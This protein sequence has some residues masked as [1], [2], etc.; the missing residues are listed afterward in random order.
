MLYGQYRFH[1]RLDRNA[2]L[3]AY[4]GSTFRGAFG[5][6]LKQVVCALKRQ[7]CDDCL[8]RGQCLYTRVFET[9]LALAPE[10][11]SRMAQV[12]HPFVIQPPLTEQTHFP[13]GADF[14]FELLLFGEF[15][16]HLPYFIY[17]FDRMGHTGLG[18]KLNGRR[19][20]FTLETV[21]LNNAEIYSKTTR[22]IQM[23]EYVPL[24]RLPDPATADPPTTRVRITLETPLRLK[25]RNRFKADLPFHVLVRAML[26]R[27]SSLMA[28]YGNGEPALD[29]TDLVARAENI[30][31][32]DST[33]KW[34][35]LRRYSNRQNS[36]LFI[37]GLAGTITYQGDMTDY[38]PL[39]EF[40]SKTHIGKQTA[41]GLG[42]ISAESVDPETVSTPG[43]IE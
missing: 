36:K 10:K 38:L 27:I 6:A 14:D 33:L 40:C 32:T 7:S 39:I 19:A 2:A 26:R 15:N 22:S 11:K 41:F 20:A 8:L 23:K 28:T 42:K 16:Q 4:K 35:D 25:Y 3:P 13:A 31:I 9:P 37:G 43:H 34:V 29:Y 24:L 1:C 30:K 18:K 5:I 17:A 21:H 12:P